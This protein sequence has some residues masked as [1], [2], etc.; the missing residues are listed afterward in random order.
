MKKKSLA[1]IIIIVLI[2]L[3]L[4]VESRKANAPAI[5]SETPAQEN[6]SSTTGTIP[7]DTDNTDN[8]SIESRISAGATGN[9]VPAGAPNATQ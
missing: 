2:G 9:E 6:R 7:T 1:I 4:F 3:I 5:S 8:S